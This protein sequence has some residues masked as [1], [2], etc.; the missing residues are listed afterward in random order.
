MGRF[1]EGNMGGRDAM[2]VLDDHETGGNALGEDRFDGGRHRAAGFSGA[3]DDHA[4]SGGQGVGLALDGYV[5]PHAPQRAPNRSSRLDGRQGGVKYQARH[6]A[7][8]FIHRELAA[9]PAAGL[10]ERAP[11]RLN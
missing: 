10:A 6:V 3:D 4:A 2:T 7:V 11:D 1:A 5:V 9:R 8:G